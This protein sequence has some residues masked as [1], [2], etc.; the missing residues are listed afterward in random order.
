MAI[1]RRNQDLINIGAYPTGS[2]A[3]ID[4]AIRL[5]EPMEK[6]L[7]QPVNQGVLATESWAMLDRLMTGVETAAVSPM[8]TAK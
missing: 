8:A 4:R 6:F 7:R 3:P 1:Y 2:N 5:R